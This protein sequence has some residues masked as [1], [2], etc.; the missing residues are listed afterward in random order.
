MLVQLD[1]V[2][3]EIWQFCTG[4]EYGDSRESGDRADRGERSGKEYDI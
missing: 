2:M 1:R 3:K 4:T